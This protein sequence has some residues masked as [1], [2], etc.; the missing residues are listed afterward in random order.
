MNSDKHFIVVNREV[1][2]YSFFEVCCATM[3]CWALRLAHLLGYHDVNVEPTCQFYVTLR[4]PPGRVQQLL[5]L[6]HQ[7]AD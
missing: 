5:S 4:Q 7:Q 1:Y 6:S 2:N 3:L